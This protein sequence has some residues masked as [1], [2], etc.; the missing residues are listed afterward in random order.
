ME[1]SSQPQTRTTSQPSG[2][3][4]PKSNFFSQFATYVKNSMYSMMSSGYSVPIPGVTGLQAE[5]TL[6]D[7]QNASRSQCVMRR[8]RNAQPEF[9]KQR[10]TD[11]YAERML[12]RKNSFCNNLNSN[13]SVIHN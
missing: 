10:R 9:R 6:V 11:R 1:T 12:K 4:H 2:V 13:G 8:E 5:K 3:V 7:Q